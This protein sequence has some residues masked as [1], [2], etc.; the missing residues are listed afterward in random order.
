VKILPATGTT[1]DDVGLFH[2]HKWPSPTLLK[3]KT[4]L[5]GHIH[6]VVVLRDPTGFKITKQVWI[7][8]QLN[9]EQLSTT[10]L[11]KQGIKIEESIEAKS[12]SSPASTTF[13]AAE[14]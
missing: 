5:M 12:S 9:T 8:A 14:P 6:P 1:L 4:L 10:L 11:R 7:K 3:C 13:S 2:G